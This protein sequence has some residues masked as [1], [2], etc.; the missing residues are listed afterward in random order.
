MRSRDR[1]AAEELALE[2]LGF[3]AADEERLSRFVYLS[4]LTVDNL[5]EAAAAPGFFAGVLDHLAGNESL[6][7]AFAANR[8]LDPAE[9]THAWRVLSAP[10]EDG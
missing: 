1:E 6:L 9:V 8:S 5:R 4:G 7:L 2:A 3:L 10:P